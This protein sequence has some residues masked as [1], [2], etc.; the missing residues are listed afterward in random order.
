[1]LIRAKGIRVGPK[2]GWCGGNVYARAYR[3]EYCIRCAGGV[4]ASAPSLAP[5]VSV[6]RPVGPRQ[7]PTAEEPPQGGIG[8][9]P[10]S[11]ACGRECQ[12]VACC[13]DRAGEALDAT[14]IWGNPL[15]DE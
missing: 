4:L 12:C 9:T 8:P 14:D 15:Q 10:G 2:C 5:P 13:T 6:P 11:Q 7:R 1:M 3:G